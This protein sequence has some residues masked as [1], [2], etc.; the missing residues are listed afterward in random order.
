MLDVVGC[1]LL[2]GGNT[3]VAVAANGAPMTVVACCR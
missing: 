3:E 1:G 2:K